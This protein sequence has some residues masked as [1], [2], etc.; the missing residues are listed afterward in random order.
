MFG[1]LASAFDYPGAL[2]AAAVEHTVEYYQAIDLLRVVQSESS[3][4]QAAHGEADDG[5][6]VDLQVFEQLAQLLGIAGQARARLRARAG[7]VAEHVVGDDLEM[8]CQTDDL[9]TPH[10]LVQADPVDQHH[11]MSL[12]GGQVA[13]A[14][15]GGFS[16]EPNH[17]ELLHGP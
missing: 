2:V 17:G 6:M 1:R 9:T 16:G 8:R 3:R 15:R 7:A 5:G 11:R 10:F 14:G 13:G 12:A 4:Y